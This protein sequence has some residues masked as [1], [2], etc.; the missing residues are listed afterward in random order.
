MALVHIK[1]PPPIAPSRFE[2][3]ELLS[4]REILAVLQRHHKLIIFCAAAGLMLGFIYII[5]TPPRFTTT[6]SLLIDP[7]QNSGL[8]QALSDGT[9][10][11]ENLVI[12]SQIEMI[13]STRLM[14][15]VASK[16]KLY[17][18]INTTQKGLVARIKQ[19]VFGIDTAKEV[20]DSV[21][22]KQQRLNAL[23][24]GMKVNRVRNTYVIAISYT[25]GNPEYAAKIANLIASVYLDD[26]LEA[27]FEASQRANEWMKG[28]LASL[29]NELSKT[30]DAVQSYKEANNILPNETHDSL[31]DQQL[32]ELNSS[33]I[34]AR[35]DSAQAKARYDNIQSIIESGNPETATIDVLNNKVI[36]ELRSK[37]LDLSRLATGI[38]RRQGKDHEAYRNLLKQM[39]DIQGLIWGEY[40]RIAESYKSELEI[41]QSKEYSLQ[42]ELDAVRGTSAI[43]SR[44]QIALRELQR[45]ADSTRNLYTKMLDKS[46]EEVERQSFPSV[47]ARIISYATAPL[48]PSWPNK[49]FVLM[50]SLL[51]GF[52]SGVGLSFLREQ[53]E[54]FMWKAEDIESTTQR[55]C[56]GMLPK[57]AFDREKIVHFT[58]RW[59]TKEL[60]VTELSSREFNASGF[61]EVTQLL[62]KQTGIITE[63]MRNV[64]LA[65]QFNKEHLDSNKAKV[66]SFVSARPG[67]GKSITS[68][69]LA[70]HLAKT[71]A[72][73]ALID[74]DFRRPSLTHWFL[75]GA[76]TGFYELASRIGHED[77]KDILLDL[78]SIC[79]KTGQEN[80]FFIPAKGHNNSITNLNLVGSGQMHTLITYL[81]QIFDVI[82]IDLPPIMNIV[83]AR[84]TA[85]SIDSFIVLAHWGKTDRDV[86]SKALRRAPEVY[87]KTVGALLTLVDTEKASRYGYYNYNYYYYYNHQPA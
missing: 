42:K 7:R 73:V 43:S 16:A 87:S 8:P 36:G 44:S 37:Y 65:I 38:L 85:N 45:R 67:E 31:S 41:A 13:G 26:E 74:C 3:D 35:A 63:I 20:Q 59:S 77:P 39:Q 10:F 81:K 78:T 9:S 27:Q 34:V 75:P 71:G 25:A 22:A 15:K 6:T 2:P 12:D 18:S 46:N 70:K 48:V 49:R 24:G 29:N 32:S 30:E 86:V 69:F 1:D 4:F 57:I 47:H 66:I 68:C 19:L 58:K 5:F 61:N 54:K 50:V 33:L 84:V 51:L 11:R 56:L 14:D 53:F 76:T 64:Q 55:T 80:L 17:E 40:H 79:R 72:R 82:L 21:R 62:E 52:A 83:D 60:S 23:I 28:R